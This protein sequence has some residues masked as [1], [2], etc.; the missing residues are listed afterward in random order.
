MGS[1]GYGYHAPP[2]LPQNL[3]KVTMLS[4]RYGGASE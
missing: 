4:V 1:L 2:E 3:L